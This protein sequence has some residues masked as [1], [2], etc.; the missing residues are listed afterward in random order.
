MQIEA[1]ALK[2]EDDAASKDRLEKL[3]KELS[4]LQQQS[5]E[6]TAKWQAERDKLDAARDSR[7]SSTMRGPS[8]IR[9]S[10]R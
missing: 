10:G 7:R 3:E 2:K 6:M 5:A 1:E 9:P 8:W 4:D